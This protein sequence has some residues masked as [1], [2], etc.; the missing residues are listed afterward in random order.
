ML[1]VEEFEHGLKVLEFL[2]RRIP[3]APSSYLSRLLKKG[4]VLRR[5]EGLR[6]EDLLQA[7]DELLLPESRRLLELLEACAGRGAGLNV[8]FES[9]RILVLDKPAGLAV[10]PGLAHEGDN[11]QARAQALLHSR[12]ESFML[13]PAHRLDLETSGPVLFG[14]GRAAC[15][16]LGGLFMDGRVRKRYLAL[17][18][19]RPVE[20]AGRLNSVIPAKGKLKEA[21]AGYR[22]LGSEAGLTLLEVCLETGRR[23][24]IRRQLAAFGLPILGDARYGVAAPPGLSRMFLH[25]RLLAFEDPFDKTPLVLESPLPAELSAFL[26]TCGLMVDPEG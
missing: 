26:Q 5:D 2:L 15:S 9:R 18:K 20:A 13:A 7:G 3:T 1:K 23:H 16:A 24:Q 17:S 6:E 22:V 19:G 8:L 21:S 14:K 11:L 12:G 25:C 4:R 10:H